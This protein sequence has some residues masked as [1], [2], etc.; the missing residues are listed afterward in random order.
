MDSN[1]KKKKRRGK[2]KIEGYPKEGGEKGV[3]G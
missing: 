1:G 3:A 2:E